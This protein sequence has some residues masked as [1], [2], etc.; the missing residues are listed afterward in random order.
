MG[1]IVFV[2]LLDRRGNVRE[3]VRVDSFPATVGRGYANAVIVDDPLVS[4][5]HL[6]LSLDS[7][8][9]VIVEALNTENGTWLSTSRERI[10]RHTISA[11][12]EAMIRIGQTVL[13][14]RGDDFVFKPATPFRPLFGPSG[15]LIENGVIADQTES[16]RLRND[17]GLLDRYLSV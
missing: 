11:G 2:E 14:L 9:G 10:E 12:G 15:R 17:N 7:E 13:R 1:K 6:R 16:A 4:V 8:G 5:E 3:R